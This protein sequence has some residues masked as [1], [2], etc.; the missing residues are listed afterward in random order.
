MDGGVAETSRSRMIAARPQMIWDV[1]S[2]FGSLSS[3]AAGVDHSCLLN[4]GADHRPLGTTRRVQVG[5]NAL[6]ERITEFEPPMSLAYEIEGMPPRLG[7]LANRWILQPAGNGTEVTVTS[8]V[9]TGRGPLAAATG[10]IVGRVMAK[11]SDSMLAGL[12]HRLENRSGASEA[13]G[14]TQ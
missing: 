7:K 3:W 2:D 11:Q 10:W 1:L 4:E 6:V 9:D 8:T 12:A 14:E 13:T 5:R